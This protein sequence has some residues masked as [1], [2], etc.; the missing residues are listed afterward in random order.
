MECIYK[1]DCSVSE[2]CPHSKPHEKHES[3][4]KE[5]CLNPLRDFKIRCKQLVKEE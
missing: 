2:K 4:N 5:R 1:N 3:C